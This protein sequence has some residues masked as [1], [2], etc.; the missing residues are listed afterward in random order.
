MPILYNKNAKK[1]PDKQLKQIANSLKEF[2]WRQ[3]ILVDKDDVIIVG[4]GRWMAYQ[5]FPE[6]IKEPWIIKVDD[7]TGEQVKAYRLADNKL[8]ESEWDMGL[9]IE[10]LKEL[11]EDMQE[12]TGF[13]LDLLIEPDEKD[14][15]IPEDVLPVAK[16]GDLWALGRHRLLCGDSTD[17]DAVSRLM[18]GIKA[19]MVFTDP[20]YNINYKGQGKNT[21]NVIMAD[22][23]TDDAFDSFLDKVF[24]NFREHTKAGGGNYVFHAS[25]TQIAFEKALAKNNYEIK[26]QLIWNKPMSALGWGDYRWKHEPFFYAGQK[27]QSIQFYGDRTQS[28]VW[29]FQKTEQQLLNWAKKQKN[30]ETNGKTTIWSMKRD[31]VHEYVHPTQKPVELISYAIK[32][33]TKADDIIMDLFGGSGSTLI[34]AEKM[35]R[36]AY[37]CELDEKYC[38]VIIKRWEDYTGNKAKKL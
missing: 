26:N 37:I 33:S 32:N 18:G 35:G 36:I 1:H 25:R 31:N 12:L 29:D 28:T 27:G 22:N 8:N 11:S 13:D 5:K 19:D 16:L 15:V 14:D 9:A 21:S 34:A 7:L 17:K 4:H 10:E 23:V 6:G 3:P 2:G 30:A 24:A 20:P 38:D